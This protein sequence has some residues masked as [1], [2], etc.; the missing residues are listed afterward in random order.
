MEERDELSRDWIKATYSLKKSLDNWAFNNLQDLWDGEFQS[1]FMQFLIN[2]DKNGSTNSEL[3][4]KCGIS[5][6]AMSKIISK[7]AILELIVLN[8]SEKDKRSQLIILTDKGEYLANE[9][10]KRF[11]ELI[12]NYLVES[13]D[14]DTKA[15]IHTLKVINKFILE[16]NDK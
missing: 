14:A 16:F 7:L 5:K 15:A 4:K 2:I 6:Q 1:S 9:S 12:P 13:I 3:A 11:T 8:S 10:I